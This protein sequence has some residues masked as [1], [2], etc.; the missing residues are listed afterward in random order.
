[1]TLSTPKSLKREEKSKLRKLTEFENSTMNQDKSS[2]KYM[3]GVKDGAEMM[4]DLLHKQERELRIA[5]FKEQIDKWK[6]AVKIMRRE[7]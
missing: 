6:N 7:K 1:M 3:R 5:N 2:D 4:W